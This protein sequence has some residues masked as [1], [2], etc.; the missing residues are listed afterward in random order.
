MNWLWITILMLGIVVHILHCTVSFWSFGSFH[1][2]FY[3]F[4]SLFHSVDRNFANFLNCGYCWLTPFFP[5]TNNHTTLV[6]TIDHEAKKVTQLCLIQSWGKKFT[7]ACTAWT[8][9]RQVGIRSVM[10]FYN[11]LYKWY[12][13][14]GVLAKWIDW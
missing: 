4:Q 13:K 12:W 1:H 2:L 14:Q 7:V 10:I 11:F 5:P 3:T 8:Q 9:W 6:D